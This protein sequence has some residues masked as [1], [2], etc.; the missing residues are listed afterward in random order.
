[1]KTSKLSYNL[2]CLYQGIRLCTDHHRSFNHVSGG[3]ASNYNGQSSS[4]LRVHLRTFIALTKAYI[5]T[6][7]YLECTFKTET[8]RLALNVSEK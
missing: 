3:F 1:M 2:S 7:Q 8:A 4:S 6:L 5:E